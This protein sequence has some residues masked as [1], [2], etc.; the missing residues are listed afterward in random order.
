MFGI[1]ERVDYAGV[2]VGRLREDDVRDACATIRAAGVEA[3]AICFLWS[4]ENP[5][6]EQRAAEIVRRRAAR[7]L[8]LGV[9]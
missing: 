9:E 8:P 6:H 7:R 3:V 1:R 5:A 4:F 2:E